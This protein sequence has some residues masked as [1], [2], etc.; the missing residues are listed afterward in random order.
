MSSSVVASIYQQV[1]DDVIRSVQR[2]FD[3]SGV[4]ISVLQELQRLWETKIIQSR[5]T[6]FPPDAPEEEY[7]EKEVE[8][9]KEYN[10]RKEESEDELDNNAE[11]TLNQFSNID[12]RFSGKSAASLASIINSPNVRGADSDRSFSSLNKNRRQDVHLDDDYDNY[13]Q[14]SSEADDTQD[15]PLSSRPPI[16]FPSNGNT[17]LSTIPENSSDASSTIKNSAPNLNNLLNHNKRV[18]EDDQDFTRTDDRLSKVRKLPHFSQND[19]TDDFDL[20]WKKVSGDFRSKMASNLDSLKDNSGIQSPGKSQIPQL[21]G[22]N[23]SSYH[24]DNDENEEINSDLD[25]SDD[26]EVENGGEITEHMVLC[27]YDKVSRTKNKWK[28]VLKD[29]IMLVNG[30]NYL[31]HRAN[32]DFEW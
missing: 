3:D 11:M 28:C 2:D 24:H 22:D 23:S 9:P 1:I 32:G 13:D 26:E 21:D 31:F 27:Q 7:E 19:G 12:S 14:E 25:D 18:S 4:D 10:E 29:G 15:E 30:R 5:V 17:L 8:N 16:Y 20:M 6:S